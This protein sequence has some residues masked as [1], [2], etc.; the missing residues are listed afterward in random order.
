MIASGGIQNA[1]DIVKSIALGA[2]FA[3]MARP[4]IQA[5]GDGGK[6]SLQK[7]FD[8][9]QHHTKIILTLIGCKTFEQCSKIHL[10][11]K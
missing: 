7:K 8:Q 3:A 9:W 10:L 1:F 6:E 11:K 4:V 2:D 5:L